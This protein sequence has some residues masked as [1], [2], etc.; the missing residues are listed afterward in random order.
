MKRKLGLLLVVILLL[1]G[2]SSHE[3]VLVPPKVDIGGSNTLAILFFDNL[4]DDYV[5]SYDVEQQLSRKLSEYY[6]VIDPTEADWALARLGLRRGETPTPD[7]VVRLGKLLDVDAILYGEVSGYFAP[8]TQTPPY[9]ARSRVGKTGQTEYQ[10]EVSRNT[11]VMIGFTGRIFSTRNGNM[12]YRSRVE[13]DGERIY[14]EVLS[15]EWIAE[16]KKPDTWFIPRPSTVDVPSARN[17][18]L[19]HS[20]DQFA[21]DLLPTYVWIKIED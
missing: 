7:E 17:T 2:C 4:T 1:S 3:R 21:A 6:R 12:I 20:V 13:G 5:L 8:V 10:W 19:K 15:P 18:A 14:K 9:I 16:G 11:Q